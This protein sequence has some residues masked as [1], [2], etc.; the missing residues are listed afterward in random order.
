MRRM[1][2][3]K[4]ILWWWIHWSHEEGFPTCLT[5]I[6]LSDIFLWTKIFQFSGESCSNHKEIIE[7]NF[8]TNE[9]TFRAIVEFYRDYSFSA[10]ARSDFKQTK[11]AALTS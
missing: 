3:L 7:S 11:R 1:Y 10:I 8:L 2:A 6:I 9:G 4:E 5:V